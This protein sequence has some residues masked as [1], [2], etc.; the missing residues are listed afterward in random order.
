MLVFEDSMAAGYCG[1]EDE[2]RQLEEAIA[3]HI[4]KEVAVVIKE[5][6]TN[7][8]FEESH[9][10]LEQVINMEITYEDE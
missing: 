1:R 6:D 4:G 10:D 5:N 7:R 2:R 8:P 9:V 3:E